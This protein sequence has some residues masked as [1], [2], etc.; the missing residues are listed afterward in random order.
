MGCLIGVLAEQ[1]QCVLWH[2][3]KTQH[4]HWQETVQK[5]HGIETRNMW[6]AEPCKQRLMVQ[7][8]SIFS[9]KY[10]SPAFEIHH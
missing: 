7:I 9:W 2:Y 3:E 6:I 10:F 8:A 4:M 1:G 5:Q